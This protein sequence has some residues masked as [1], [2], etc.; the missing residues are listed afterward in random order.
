MPPPA[1]RRQSTIASATV[2][3]Q[4]S[5]AEPGV[6]KSNKA[7]RVLDQVIGGV[8]F[9]RPFFSNR[10]HAFGQPARRQLV[11]MVL[12]DQFAIGALDICSRRVRRHTECGVGIGESILRRLTRRAS[13]RTA[14]CGAQQRFQLSNIGLGQPKPAGDTNQ[15][16]VLGGMHISISSDCH[17][18]Q[19]QKKLY[20]RRTPATDSSKSI[21]RDIEVKIRL[22][23]FAECSPGLTALLIIE[24][25]HAKDLL[26]CL[27]L[28]AS[29]DAVDLAERTHNGKHGFDQRR[30]R[31]SQSSDHESLQ[32]LAGEMA[33]DPADK[34]PEWATC[35]ET[36]D[37]ANDYQ[38]HPRS[39]AA[40]ASP[41]HRPPLQ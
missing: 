37:C 41:T 18:L 31:D 29:N 10:A 25:Q 30:L 12:A 7:P 11:R 24:A 17:T 3:Q 13:C 4:Y 27:D 9:A 28:V 1:E 33:H 21:H 40:A 34:G 14:C 35:K 2:G 39:L 19:L 20:E 15:H 38:K 32:S 22:F 6:F 23:P 36:Y 16:G 26:N 5:F 8:Y